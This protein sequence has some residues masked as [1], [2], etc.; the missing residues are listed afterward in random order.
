MNENQDQR[1]PGGSGSNNKRP[2]SPFFIFLVFSLIALF[3]TSLIYGRAGS[4]SSEEI[5]YSQF[6]ELGR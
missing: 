2:R 1:D 4:S 5:T 3:I 6:L